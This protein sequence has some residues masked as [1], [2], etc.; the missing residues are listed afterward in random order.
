[1]KHEIA[2]RWTAALRSGEYEQGH[3]QLHTRLGSKDKYCCLGVLCEL[4]AQENVV[5]VTI[6]GGALG[7]ERLY[8]NFGTISPEVAKNWAG[9][10]SSCGL[11]NAV[12]DYQS[13][14]SINDSH[15]YSFDDIAKIIDEHWEEL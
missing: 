12:P 9:M 14:V 8:A 6:T 13:L 15:K 4:A 11:I 2:K 10:R 5:Q 3:G 1:M 7:G